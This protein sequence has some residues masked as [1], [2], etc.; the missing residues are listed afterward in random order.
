MRH[1][2]GSY[3]LGLL[4][5]ATL[6]SACTR[7]PEA[8]SV[9]VE[10]TIAPIFNQAPQVKPTS[11]PLIVPTVEPNVTPRATSAEPTTL[12]VK[13]YGDRLASG[14]S[15]ESSSGIVFTEDETTIAH[16]GS[17]AIAARPTQAFGQLI[18]GLQ[19]GT[20]TTY[21]RDNVLG[22]TFMV[23]G[24]SNILPSDGLIVT[25]YGSKKHPYFVPGDRSATQPEGRITSDDPLFPETRL[26]FLGLNRDILPG[27]WAEI[28]VWLDDHFTPDYTYITALQ[29]KNDE[30]YLDPFYV[31]DVALVLLK[32]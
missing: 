16:S 10:P 25:V 7:Q 20:P 26:Y 28:T 22:V 27:E 1:R 9:V 21:R 2:P 32:P 31:D 29:I 12:D 6:A 11:R 19:S 18:L 23:S 8:S 4:L 13:V 14:W 5:A 17:T 24:G 30:R 15:L 3:C